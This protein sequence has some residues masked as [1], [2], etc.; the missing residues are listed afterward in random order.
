[1]VFVRPPSLEALEARLH[2]RG[3]ET[4]ERLSTRLGAAAAE[5]ECARAPGL[6]DAAVVNDNVEDG[7]ARLRAAVARLMPGAIPEPPPAPP[8]RP[9]SALAPPAH[10]PPPAVSKPS[11]PPGGL[12]VPAPPPAGSKPST[13]NGRPL[14]GSKPGT[15]SRVQDSSGRGPVPPPQPPVASARPPTQS[16][17]PAKAGAPSSSLPVRQYMVSCGG[18]RGL[19][20][21]G[22]EGRALFLKF[23][24]YP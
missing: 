17:P 16:A 20:C 22:M 6:F 24:F 5:M 10:A 13:P 23:W 9:A 8:S 4:E 15:P 19:T 7:Y 14:A 12:A 1:M 3:T 2:G 11:T 18:L 21:W